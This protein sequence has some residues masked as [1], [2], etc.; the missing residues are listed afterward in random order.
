M[1]EFDEID[2]ITPSRRETSRRVSASSVRTS[3]PSGASPRRK[4]KR[5]KAGAKVYIIRG[6][7]TF[8]ATLLIVFVFLYLVMFML[9]HGPSKHA[10]DLFVVSVRESS[11]MGFLAN[12]FYSEEEVQQIISNNSIKD[13]G[14][15]TDTSLFNKPNDTNVVTD[16]QQPD[17][18]VVDIKGSTYRGK[19]MIVKDPSRVFVG[20]VPQFGDGDGTVVAE[21]AQR[22]G[23]VAGINGGEFV[24]GLTTYTAKPVGLVMKDGEVLHGGDYTPGATY[25]VT[26]LTNDNVLVVGNMNEDKAKELGIRDC[27]S[28]N[29]SIGPFL[30][31]NGEA[32]EVNGM[33]GGLNP[34]TAIGQRADKSILLLVIDGRQVNA[35]GASFADLIYI[36]QE[37]GAVNASTM[38][39]GTSTQ[40]Y[41]NGEVINNPYSPTGPRQCPTSFLVGGTN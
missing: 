13:S 12:W 30:I 10:A 27:V 14:E 3:R 17:I 16:T 8:L 11:A 23:A 38:D 33:G 34:R 7:L 37:Y 9:V 24:D 39:G 2:D 36:M 15:V 41:Y 6:L 1:S 18:E 19:L 21:M 26:G 32:Q 28:I 29:N 4:K 31:I 35:M 40:M 5:K 25:H 20:T 22:Y